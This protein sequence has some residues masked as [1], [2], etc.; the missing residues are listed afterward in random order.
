MVLQSFLFPSL[1]RW[2]GVRSS[3]LA[4]APVVRTLRIMTY[5]LISSDIDRASEE[6]VSYLKSQ[7]VEISQITKIR[8]GAEEALLR[9][10]EQFGDVPFTLKTG[11]AFGKI[12]VSLSVQGTMY[13]PFAQTDDWDTESRFMRNALSSAGALPSWRYSRGVNTV[14]FSVMNKA[15][16]EWIHLVVAVAAAV[17][18]WGIM[19]LLPPDIN[20]FVHEQVISPVLSKF[21][22]FLGAVAGP[23]IFLSIVWGIY[24]I[25]D[26]AVFSVLGKRLGLRFLTYTVLLTIVLGACLLPFFSLISGS[27]EIGNDYSS[28]YN[29]VL[30]IVPENLFTPFSRGNTLQILFVGICMGLAMIFVSEKTQTVAILAEQLTYIVQAIMNFISKLVP[31]FIFG[32]IYDIL[33]S[34]ELAKLSVSYKLLVCNLAGCV[35]LAL[36]YVLL[37]W[38]RT[39]T[40]PGVLLK[41]ALNTLIICLTTASSA[42]VF[43]TSVETC[44][45]RYGIKDKFVN[46][47]VPFSQVIYKPSVALL[48]A[49]SAICAA[50]FYGITVSAAWIVIA[51][52]VSVI[53]AFATPPVPGGATASF[54]ILFSQLK[55]PSEAIAITL[56]VSIIL[57]FFE[58]TVD[59]FGGQCMLILGAKN[60]NML[61]EERLQKPYQEGKRA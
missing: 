34:G 53:L 45:E 33:A 15:V 50:E 8:L 13:D 22:G 39:K 2:K 3:I 30:D 1:D 56:A 18:F 7:S 9:F 61:D 48:Y 60:L 16:P 23:M 51:L 21:L 17:L 55:I 10:M 58:T 28:I 44:R 32:S 57:D 25:G 24:S 26:A 43:G 49:T 40:S 4:D 6:I 52:L 38:V 54:A 35:A 41:K 31:L 37:V 27:G 42:A 19:Q 5:Q 29:M 12:N 47:G 59:I 46:F 11:K 14:V 36:I 20:S